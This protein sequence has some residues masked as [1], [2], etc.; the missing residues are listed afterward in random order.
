MQPGNSNRYPVM[1][2]QNKAHDKS[3]D[4]NEEDS[5]D[6]GD[7]EGDNE[8]TAAPANTGKTEVPVQEKKDNDDPQGQV[9]VRHLNKAERDA[10]YN[11]DELRNFS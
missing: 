8:E 3:K 5:G 2:N 7:S 11:T 4:D 10:Y 1:F 9:V 6:E